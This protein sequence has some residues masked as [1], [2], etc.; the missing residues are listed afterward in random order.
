MIAMIIGLV[1]EVLGYVAKLQLH[2]NLFSSDAF[3]L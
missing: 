2:D 3:L 1:L